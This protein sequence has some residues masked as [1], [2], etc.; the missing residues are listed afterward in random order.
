MDAHRGRES[1]HSQWRGSVCGVKSL[2]EFDPGGEAVSVGIGV[3][4]IAQ[5][6]EILEFLGVDEAVAVLVFGRRIEAN[7]LGL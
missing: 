7:Y 5:G 4:A 1:E 2:L 3:C 6:G